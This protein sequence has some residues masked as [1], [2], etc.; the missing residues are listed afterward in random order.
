[1]NERDKWVFFFGGNQ[2]KKPR[3]PPNTRA[4][5]AVLDLKY[6]CDDD[7]LFL[8]PRSPGVARTPGVASYEPDNHSIASSTTA[9]GLGGI[10][11]NSGTGNPALHNPNNSDLRIYSN[12]SSN[13]ALLSPP[14]ARQP[15]GSQSSNGR[16]PL[17]SSKGDPQVNY[18]P[19]NSNN[20][21]SS[22]NNLNHQH[23]SMSLQPPNSISIDAPSYGQKFPS[24]S[25]QPSPSIAS[26]S[27][28]PPPSV[29]NTPGS[30]GALD[31]DEEIMRRS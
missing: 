26:R 19:Q 31:S 14:P 25:G 11:G 29:I 27:H 13:G 5:A 24:S 17:N 15:L 2:R 3:E 16:V 20:F 12:S 30:P 7:F 28:F 23:A 1:M 21:S 10:R 22:S 9:P 8:D 6:G 4:A 18:N